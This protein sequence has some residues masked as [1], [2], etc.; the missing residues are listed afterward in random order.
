M[1]VNNKLSFARISFNLD[2]LTIATGLY[3]SIVRKEM[4]IGF[5]TWIKGKKGKT[6]KHIKRGKMKMIKRK[7]IV[8]LNGNNVRMSVQWYM[9]GHFG[10]NRFIKMNP[11]MNFSTFWQTKQFLVRKR[12]NKKRNKHGNTVFKGKNSDFEIC[13]GLRMPEHKILKILKE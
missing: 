13:K 5:I 8:Y 6:Q 7:K 10:L 2:C 4:E 3:R 1:T 9:D 12:K 11:K